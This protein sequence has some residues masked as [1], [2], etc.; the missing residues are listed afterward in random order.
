MKISPCLEVGEGVR[1][2]GDEEEGN[3][4]IMHAFC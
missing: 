3:K 4:G 2:A 1:K